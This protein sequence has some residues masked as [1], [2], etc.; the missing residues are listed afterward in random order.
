VDDLA[1]GGAV[2]GVLGDRGRQPGREQVVDLDGDDP[3]GHLEQR[4]GERTET[5]ADLDDD[6][7]EIDPGL[8]NDATHGVGVDHEVLTALPG[9]PEVELGGQ[10]PNLGRPEQLHRTRHHDGQA[11]RGASKGSIS[12]VRRDAR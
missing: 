11:S 12:R 10:P 8:T 7:V 6:V 2:T 5:G 4:E 3:G 1:A 9:R